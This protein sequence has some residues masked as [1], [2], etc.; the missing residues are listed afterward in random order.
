MQN[1][2]EILTDCTLCYHSC[3]CRVS[4]ENGKAV[5]VRG[6]ESHPLNKGRLCPKGGSA[7]DVIYSPERLKHPLKRVN[8]DFEEISWEQAL[9]EI[10]EKMISLKQKFGPRVLGVF[11]GSIGVENL[12]MAGLVQRFKAAFGSPNFFSV[13]SICYRMRI[14]VRQ[15]TFG[16]YPVEE[17]DSNLYILWGHNPDQSDFPLKFTLKKNLKKGAKLVVID[18]KRIPVAEKADMYLRIRPGTDGALALA[19]MNVIVNED[20]YD[21][22]FVEK[23]TFGFD[24]L[25]PHVQQY[26]PQW[27]EELTWV[28]AEDIRKLARLFA[29]TKGASIFQGTCTLDQTANGT[30]NSRAFAV[31]Q[32]ITGNINVPGGWVTAPFPRFGNVGLSVEGEPM[33]S[34]EF[35]LF[36]EMWGRKSPHGVVTVIPENIP[37]KLKAFLVVGGNP[38]ISMPD[39]NAFRQAFRKLDLLVVHDLFMTETAREAH[40]VLPA[41]SHLEKWGVAYTYNVCHSIPFLMLRKKCIEPIGESWSEWKFLTELAKRLGMGDQFPW[42]TEEE[43]VA[44]E[45]APSGLSFDYLLNEKP[46]GDFYAQKRY[47]ITEGLFRV[48]TGKIE[49][50]SETLAKAGFDP[51][52]TYLEP[53]R[54]PKRAKKSFLEKYPL[55]L[56]TGSR[57]L[58]YTHSQHRNVSKLRKVF[59]EPLAEIGPETAARFNISDGDMVVIETNRGQVKMK[60]RVDERVAEGVVLVP[61]GWGEEANANLL[62]DV[63][64]REPIMGYPDMKSLQCSIRKA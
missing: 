16:R 9:D 23:Y 37:E 36:I 3:G 17:M 14:R 4:L 63:E 26:T 55:I 56:S 58:Y 6:L 25:V 42:K 61:H 30:Q 33:G 47:E 21:H 5:K 35:P 51:L 52:P 34:E 49:I 27:A 54:S 60:A 2:K 48:P 40:Y 39:S 7:L 32:A 15:L 45:L 18:P 44:F 50:Y 19:M 59:P 64:C 1:T 38:L 41:C 57:N 62:T 46:E 29:G 43:L 24:K 13:E 8:G 22:D 28:P 12:E 11:S 20:L 10:A 53:E 31:L